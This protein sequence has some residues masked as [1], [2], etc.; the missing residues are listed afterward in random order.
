MARRVVACKQALRLR[1]SADGAARAM[2]VQWRFRSISFT[3]LLGYGRR[4]AM[5]GPFTM[6]VALLTDIHANV[7]ALDA[8]LGAAHAAGAQRFVFLG[9]LIGYGGDPGPVLDRI[10]AMHADGAIV[11]A[12]NHDDLDANPD[13]EMHLAAAEAAKWTRAQLS[14]AQA[15][16]LRGLPL[17]VREDDR[18]YV[19]ADA[20]APARWL[21]V[22]NA[23]AAGRSLA[24]TDARLVICGHVHAPMVYML[25]SN[26][27]AAPFAPLAG[28]PCALLAHRRWHVVLGS[29]GQ[30]RNGDPAASFAIFD[31][32]RSE[33]IFHRVG[34]DVAA[35]AQRIRAQGLPESLAARLFVGR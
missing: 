10:M 17:T 4:R 8:A 29:V 20:S 32:A 35:A 21:Y 14:S 12:G 13:K 27:R 34:Y 7:Q 1:L 19:H 5:G 9:D 18:L 3:S 16:F 2:L 26:A 28:K 31:T 23:E 22:M 25:Q 6:R 33:I 30:P 15:T 11:L 24:A